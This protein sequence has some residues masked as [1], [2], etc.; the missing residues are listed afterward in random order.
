[1]QKCPINDSLSPLWSCRKTWRGFVWWDFLREKK[2]YIWV[3]FLDPEGIKILSLGV[4]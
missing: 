4:I 2:K 3:R 1:M